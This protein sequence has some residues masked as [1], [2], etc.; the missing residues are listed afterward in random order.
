[1]PNPGQTVGG[2]IR[3]LIR[4]KGFAPK[5]AVAASLNMQRAGKLRLAPRG[6]RRG[7]RR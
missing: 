6:P 3:H 5:R 7:P 1:M 4:D 2:E